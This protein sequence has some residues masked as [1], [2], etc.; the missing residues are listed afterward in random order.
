MGWKAHEVE[1]TSGGLARKGESPDGENSLGGFLDPREGR[2][3][4][5]ELS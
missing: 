1:N 2:N 4:Q 5:R 3:A